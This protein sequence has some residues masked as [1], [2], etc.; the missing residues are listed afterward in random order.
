MPAERRGLRGDRLAPR[1]A[2]DRV[3]EVVVVLHSPRYFARWLQHLA[4]TH[5][6]L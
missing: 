1:S 3:V 2:C 4:N 5:E 6:G